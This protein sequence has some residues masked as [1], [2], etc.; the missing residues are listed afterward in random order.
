MRCLCAQILPA[1]N[2]NKFVDHEHGVL[3]EEED[4]DDEEEELEDIH[5][6]SSVGMRFR[7]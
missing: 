2:C 1:I 5:L 4:D 7:T 3:V 6:L